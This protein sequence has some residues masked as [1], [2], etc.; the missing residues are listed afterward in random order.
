MSFSEQ[1][2]VDCSTSEGNHGCQ[3]G[4]MDYAFNYLKSHLEEMEEDYPYTAKVS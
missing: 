1:E 4:L 3:G 2:L